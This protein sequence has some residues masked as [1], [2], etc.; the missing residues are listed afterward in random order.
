MSGSNRQQT[1]ES[2][3]GHLHDMV[4]ALRAEEPSDG[5]YAA[6]A[7]RLRQK[8]PTTSIDSPRKRI[9]KK[10]VPYSNIF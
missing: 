10:L 6:V 9:S 4:E 5:E 8:L 7:R 3:L 2:E 1:P